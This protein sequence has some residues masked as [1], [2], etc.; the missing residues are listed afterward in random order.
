[1]YFTSVLVSSNYVLDTGE[2]IV[3]SKNQQLITT[4]R[5]L[6]IKFFVTF[7]K[8]WTST[9]IFYKKKKFRE[10]NVT[11]SLFSGRQ[12]GSLRTKPSKKNGIKLLDNN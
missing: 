11:I 5:I 10:L 2:K 12:K 7:Q 8:F 6:T 3:K 9:T 4:Q 1:M